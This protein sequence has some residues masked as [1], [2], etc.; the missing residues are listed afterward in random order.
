VSCL[1]ELGSRYDLAD[2]LGYR[3]RLG[4]RG[5]RQKDNELLAT[6]AADNILFSACQSE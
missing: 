3:S 1:R 2:P 4:E 6:K 5:F